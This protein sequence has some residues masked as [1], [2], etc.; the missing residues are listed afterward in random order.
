MSNKGNIRCPWHGEHGLTIGGKCGY[1]V[2]EGR[3]TPAPKAP[4]A[5]KTKVGVKRKIA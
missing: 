5:T 1:C 4:I 2:A 3:S